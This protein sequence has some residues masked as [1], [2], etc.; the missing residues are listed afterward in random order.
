MSQIERERWWSD[1]MLNYDNNTLKTLNDMANKNIAADL[2]KIQ[3]RL[4]NIID[5][6]QNAIE[7]GNDLHLGIVV[8]Q[9]L[10]QLKDISRR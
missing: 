5:A 3:D 7:K 10:S 1:Y 4:E 8:G 2:E 9:T 6:L